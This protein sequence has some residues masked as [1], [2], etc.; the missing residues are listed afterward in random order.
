[1]KQVFALLNEFIYFIGILFITTKC[2]KN[3]DS[4]LYFFQ[5]VTHA[6]YTEHVTKVCER[7]TCKHA[8]TLSA[9]FH[10]NLDISKLDICVQRKILKFART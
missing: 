10:G 9:E 6:T 2:T 3:I 4:Y 1:M 5:T 8:V 7:K